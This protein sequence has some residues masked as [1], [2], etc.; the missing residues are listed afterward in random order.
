MGLMRPSDPIDP[1][2]TAVPF[3]AKPVNAGINWRTI[4]RTG[5]S[6]REAIFC[7]RCSLTRLTAELT[8]LLTRPNAPHLRQ[9]ARSL[10]DR[11]ISWQ[12]NLPDDMHHAGEISAD[13]LELQ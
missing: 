12:E 7:E 3:P 5:E 1:R 6:W 9:T 2:L 8:L 11:L 4:E 10:E 13:L